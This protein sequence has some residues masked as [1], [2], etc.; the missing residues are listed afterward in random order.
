M[1][2]LQCWASTWRSS[3]QRV[4]CSQLWQQRAQLTPFPAPS[5]LT[6]G[7][8]VVIL[9]SQCPHD[10]QLTGSVCGFQN[11][12]LSSKYINDWKVW[13]GFYILRRNS[14]F[15]TEM[16][17]KQTNF[18]DTKHTQVGS[19]SGTY[20]PQHFCYPQSMLSKDLA[21]HTLRGKNSHHLVLKIKFYWNTAID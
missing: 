6:T 7:P 9:R 8:E 13:P 5:A 17:N 19:K 10:H 14:E 21:K 16:E 11:A 3:S 4:S 20:F 15:S 1:C 12:M 18:T 2:S